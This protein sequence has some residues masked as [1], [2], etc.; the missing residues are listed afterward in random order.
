MQDLASYQES[1]FFP[2]GDP[3]RIRNNGRVTC[4]QVFSKSRV[5]KAYQAQ[6]E[7]WQRSEITVILRATSCCDPPQKKSFSKSRLL[8]VE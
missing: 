4:T 8:S 2:E 6:P 3:V 7:K 1:C 5:P